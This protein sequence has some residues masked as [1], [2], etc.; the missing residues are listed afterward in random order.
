[1]KLITN[2]VL[3]SWISLI[4][5]VQHPDYELL[6]FQYPILKNNKKNF[7]KTKFKIVQDRGQRRN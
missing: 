5:D 6:I 7:N 3:K 1:M 4:I 2:A